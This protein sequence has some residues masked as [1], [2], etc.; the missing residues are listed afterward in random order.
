MTAPQPAEAGQALEAAARAVALQLGWARRGTS[1]AHAALAGARRCEPLRHYPAQDIVD[2]QAGT[3]AYYHAHG[4]R[5]RP[6]DEHGHFHLFARHNP[7]VPGDFLH[8]AG[9]SL[10][11]RGRPLRWFTTNR[12]VT[13]ERWAE[14]DEVAGALAAFRLRGR[15]RLAPVAAWLEAMVRLYRDDLARLARRRDALIARRLAGTHGAGG[16][17]RVDRETLFEDRR[18]DVVAERRIDLPARAAQLLRAA[19]SP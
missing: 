12:W 3:L 18:L 7:Q 6:A 10:D 19:A 4:S 5:R 16:A 14:A 9:L 13:G 8:L 2:A 1:L 17:G 15:G 11:E